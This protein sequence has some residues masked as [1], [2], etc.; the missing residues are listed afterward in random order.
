[1]N[2]AEDSVSSCLSSGIINLAQG[3]IKNSETVALV[4]FSAIF[5]YLLCCNNSYL[6]MT[7]AFTFSLPDTILAWP[8]PAFPIHFYSPWSQCCSVLI[9]I[10]YIIW[11]SFRD[12]SVELNNCGMNYV[13]LINYHFIYGTA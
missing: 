10:S 9:Y 2:Q 6:V 8:T 4:C 3:L 5:C 7:I 11:Y 1:M 13:I 12:L